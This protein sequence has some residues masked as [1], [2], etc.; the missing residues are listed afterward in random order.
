[1]NRL[2]LRVLGVVATLAPTL[3]AAQQAPADTAAPL[4]LAGVTVVDVERGRLLPDRDVVVRGS[5]IAS[6]GPAGRART[7]AGAR[8]VDARGRYLIPG[9]WDMHV[10]S[11]GD[12]EARTVFFPLYLANGVTGVRHMF[13]NA[14]VLR[15]RA[16]VASGA[17]P[18]PR[19]VVGSPIV[20]GPNPMWPGSVRISTAAEAARA[21][22]SISAGGYDFVKSYQF[23]PREAYFGL[24]AAARKRGF[25]VSGHVPFS[26]GAGEASDSGQKSLEHLVGVSLACSSRED[27][28][29]AVLAAA[30][31]AVD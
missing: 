5:R 11:G 28:L 24:L 4:V 31:A 25:P 3:A 18:G 29:R 2:A 7:P 14:A 6:V 8:T 13:G 27:S 30:A 23:I 12:R 17:Q 9:L 19:L 20:D 22:D 16:D 15:Q 10:H 26:A 1:M 21:L